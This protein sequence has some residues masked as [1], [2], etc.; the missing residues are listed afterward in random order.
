M[1]LGIQ[2]AVIENQANKLGVQFVF[3]ELDMALSFLSIADN[4]SSPDRR[5]RLIANAKKAHD[6]V[7][8][9]IPHLVF[10]ESEA[11]TVNRRLQQIRDRLQSHGFSF[12]GY[13][14][15]AGY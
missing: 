10:S 11:S 15:L 6:T 14:A 2:P 12:E 13:S 4:I 8:K 9:F 1:R 3:A 7:Q 5:Q